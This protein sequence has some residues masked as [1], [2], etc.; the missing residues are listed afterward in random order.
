MLMYVNS[1]ERREIQ[2]NGNQF[3]QGSAEFSKGAGK[4]GT[5]ICQM[6]LF[7]GIIMLMRDIFVSFHISSI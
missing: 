4:F 7:N 5:D 3:G 2:G 6:V 1:L